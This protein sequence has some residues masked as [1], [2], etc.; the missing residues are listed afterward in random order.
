MKHC[1]FVAISL[2]ILF[3]FNLNLSAQELTALEILKKSDEVG[4]APKDQHQLS[5]MILIDKDG[6]TKERET[7]MFERG[8]EDMRLVRF[9][10]PADQKGISFLS[11]PDDKMYV[12]FPAFRKIRTIASHVKNENFAGTDFSYDD[13]SSTGF[14]PDY[15][16][17]LLETTDEFYLLKLIPKPEAEKDYSNLHLWVRKDNFYPVKTEYYDKGGNLWKVMERR[18]IEK[19]G[20]YWIAME[21]EMKDLKKDHSTRSVIDTV[22]LDTGLPDEIFTKRNLKKLK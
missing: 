19:N 15:D 6:D 3:T 18:K 5:T 1:A 14:A 16:P 22:E 9:L 20:N 21:M 13:I 11:L 8:K 2:S 4:T 12:Y 17:E 7:E 10:S